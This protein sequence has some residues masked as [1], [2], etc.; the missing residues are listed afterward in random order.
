MTVKIQYL[1][2]I[3]ITTHFKPKSGMKVSIIIPYN[4]SRGFLGEAVKSA[5]N[6]EG[7][8]LNKD[9]EIIVQHGNRLLGENINDALEKCKGK[10]IKILADDDLLAPGCLNA[11]YQT[12]LKCDFVCADAY[13]FDGDKSVID[14]YRSTIPDFVRD[15]ADL[16]TIHG[17]T[18]LYRKSVMPKWNVYWTAEEYAVSLK[19]ASDGA[20]FAK[21]D[22]VVYWYRSHPNQKS[23][24][25]KYSSSD[26]AVKRLHFIRDV[27]KKPYFDNSNIINK[28]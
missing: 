3:T 19:M 24:I 8:K 17:G 5:E 22:E 7:W 20:K 23:I 26:I 27:I 2:S 4:I 15:L 25:Y 16:N 9:Y 13:T 14:I 11:L 1:I 12:A 21:V 6:Q 10:F 28:I 18:I